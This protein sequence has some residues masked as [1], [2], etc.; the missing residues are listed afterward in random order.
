MTHVTHPI[1]VTHLTHDP[2]TH[3]LLWTGVM[4]S[5]LPALTTRRA[6][7]FSTICSRLMTAAADAPYK[8]CVAVVNSAGNECCGQCTMVVSGKWP[9]YSTQLIETATEDVS[10]LGIRAEFTVD[11][12]AKVTDLRRSEMTFHQQQAEISYANCWRVP[13]RMNSVLSAFNFSRLDDIHASMSAT[14]Q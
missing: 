4:C 6:A 1:F 9:P 7:A 3:S 13:S 11:D 5:Y 14:V 8:N 12:H 2:S 10:G